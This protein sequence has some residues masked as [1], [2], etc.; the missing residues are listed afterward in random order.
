[1]PGTLISPTS[2][3]ATVVGM[4]LTAADGVVSRRPVAITPESPVCAAELR[5]AH[6]SKERR[7]GE[8]APAPP[9]P[10]PRRHEV[11]R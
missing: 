7:L 5:T 3:S 9:S 11:R 8:R 4:S 2:D 10:A 6:P 1:M